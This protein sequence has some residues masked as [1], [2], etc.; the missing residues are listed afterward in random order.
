MVPPSVYGTSMCPFRIPPDQV[1]ETR[2]GP[3]PIRWVADEVSAIACSA[4]L[5]CGSQVFGSKEGSKVD[6]GRLKELLYRFNMK[7]IEG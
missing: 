7:L 2:S 3:G 6:E 5:Q 1:R 4:R